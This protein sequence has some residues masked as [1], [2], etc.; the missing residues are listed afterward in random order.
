M[1]QNRDF[2]RGARRWLF[3]AACAALASLSPS[4][5]AQVA[6]CG[7]FQ[8]QTLLPISGDSVTATPTITSPCIGCAVLNPALAIN[9][10][11]DDYAT[12][13]RGLGV[14]GGI[15]LRVRNP[16]T[17]YPASRAVGI[18]V[19][20]LIPVLV[21]ARYLGIW[22]PPVSVVAL[23]VPLLLTAALWTLTAAR[24]QR[25]DADPRRIEAPAG[26][27]RQQQLQRD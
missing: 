24:S 18:V 21:H 5:M 4:A 12:L 13:T 20:A 15:S 17:L 25:A 7:T 23:L 22:V 3:A 8:S 26:F 14:F 19:S 11:V 16:A 9:S 2:T 1:H 6:N 10:N 27:P